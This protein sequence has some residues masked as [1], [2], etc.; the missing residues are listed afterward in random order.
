MVLVEFFLL[1]RYTDNTAS[2]RLIMSI[3]WRNSGKRTSVCLRAPGSAPT[4]WRMA[5]FK[6]PRRHLHHSAPPVHSNDN[7]IWLEEVHWHSVR[8]FV[9]RDRVP[10][11]NAR[12][13]S[14]TGYL[15]FAA[16][17]R[18]WT[19]SLADLQWRNASWAKLVT[20]LIQKRFNNYVIFI[21]YFDVCNTFSFCSLFCQGILR[22]GSP[23]N[24]RFFQMQHWHLVVDF[25]HSVCAE[26]SLLS[27]R[28]QSPAA[29]SALFDELF[30][31]RKDFIKLCAHIY[32][33]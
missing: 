12:C 13:G 14:Q 11:S 27:R 33:K 8:G 32:I 20:K 1:A 22:I 7:V 15:L 10:S 2:F 29:P 24:L 9:D 17:G 30:L 26:N 28:R 3:V 25:V 5:A 19:R 31:C 21:I 16:R 18:S 23:L 6:R 4:A